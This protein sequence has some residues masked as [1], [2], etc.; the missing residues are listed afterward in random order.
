VNLRDIEQAISDEKSRIDAAH[1][2]VAEAREALER[3]ER[4]QIEATLKAEARIVA[5]EAAA[6]LFKETGVLHSVEQRS[7]VKRKMEALTDNHRLNISAGRG[8]KDAFLM[9]IREKGYTLRSLAKAL[10]VSA[11]ML[12][13]NRRTHGVP[14][15]RAEKIKALTG[16]PADGKHWPAGILS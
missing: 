2:A 8:G 6:Q 7:T 3:A 5:L 10:N 11:S 16:W 13:M 12:S 14:K 9:H 4:A 1:A 15:A